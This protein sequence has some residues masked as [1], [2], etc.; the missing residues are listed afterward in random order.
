[1]LRQDTLSV[2]GPL[3]FQSVVFGMYIFMLGKILAIKPLSIDNS[4][5]GRKRDL[6]FRGC[7]KL[8][9]VHLRQLAFEAIRTHQTHRG[10]VDE[11]LFQEAHGSHLIRPERSEI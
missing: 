2:L 5:A 9:L 8:C 7:R 11:S 6:G 10:D 4:I 3:S 1:V